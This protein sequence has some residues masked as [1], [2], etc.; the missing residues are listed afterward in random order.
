MSKA[1]VAAAPRALHL[2]AQ[3]DSRR[4]ICAWLAGA[5]RADPAEDHSG[6]RGDHVWRWA[7]NKLGG[8]KPELVGDGSTI[9]FEKIAALMPDLILALYAGLMVLYRPCRWWKPPLSI[10]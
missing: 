9:A 3:R 7:Q 8:T 2:P 10:A 6:R 1:L 5:R 4:G